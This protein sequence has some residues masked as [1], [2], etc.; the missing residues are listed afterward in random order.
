MY[1]TSNYVMI[2]PILPRTQTSASK[3][4]L[5]E[6]AAGTSCWGWVLDVGE[7]TADLMGQT[8]P[9][10]F[11]AGDLVY[12]AKYSNT[13]IDYKPEGCGEIHVVHEGDVLLKQ[14]SQL[15]ADD[16]REFAQSLIPMGNFIRIE[17]MKDS[18]EK[19]TPGGIVLPDVSVKRPSKA[20]VLAVGGGQRTLNSTYSIPIKPGDIVRYL[21][22]TVIEISYR[23]LDID[24]P[25]THIVS[26]GD[27]IAVETAEMFAHIKAQIERRD[28][29]LGVR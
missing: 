5:T 14:A 7:G 19:V 28:E 4:I 9:P 11:K 12:Y 13:P 20:K 16:P 2:L 24:I 26:Y 10:P 1:A 18:V 6:K 27:V 25:S 8:V 15:Y 29:V 21:D 17:L 22:A 23:D 3:I